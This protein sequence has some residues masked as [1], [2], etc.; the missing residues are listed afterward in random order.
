MEHDESTDERTDDSTDEPTDRAA[1]DPAD[2]PSDTEAGFDAL[3]ERAE[4]GGL[5]DG[6]SPWGDSHFQRHYSWPAA[7]DLLPDVDGERVLLAGCGRGDHV[8]W[9]T[10]RG[11][12]VVGVDASE[13]AVEAARERFGD[14]RAAFRHADLTDP[15][16]FADG[17]FDL[18]FSHLVLGHVR[19][20]DPTFR[21]FARV[22]APAGTLAFAVVHPAYLRDTRDLEG[23]YETRALPVSWPGAT[24]TTYYR[25]PSAMLGPLL[26]AG[27]RLETFEEPRPREAF[28]EHAPERYAAAMERPEVLCVRARVDGT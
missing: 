9:F 28:E 15:L 16:P 18:V 20:W 10:E 14:D 7:R 23:Y 19:D 26:R 12:N 4:T 25:P 27:F 3:A 13:R 24:V 5:D 8:E 22:L 2:N 6:T 1:S 17:A 11:A 21:E